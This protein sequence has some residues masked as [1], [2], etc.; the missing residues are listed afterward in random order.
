MSNPV[1]QLSNADIYQ[2]DS[3]VLSKVNLTINQGEFYYLIGK[4]GSVKSSLMNKNALSHQVT[5][6]F[7]G[8]PGRMGKRILNL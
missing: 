8:K 4:T 3:L 1:L 7:L 2:R 6:R 5:L